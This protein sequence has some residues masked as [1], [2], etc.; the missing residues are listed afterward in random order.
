MQRIVC[1]VYACASD[2]WLGAYVGVRGKYAKRSFTAFWVSSEP[3]LSLK[4]K[5]NGSTSVWLDS[6]NAI[7]A[8]A[9][10]TGRPVLWPQQNW[11]H[12]LCNTTWQAD[13]WSHC[14][15]KRFSKGK[16]FRR[17]ILKDHSQALKGQSAHGQDLWR[18][19]CS[20]ETWHSRG[21]VAFTLWLSAAKS[22]G[23]D[24]CDS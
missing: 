1:F 7:A 22:A 8:G 5:T 18:C 3:G 9:L 17:F 19:C 16:P 21:S 6:G 23:A 14:W 15:L 12:L 2:P 10:S 13:S 24:R 20:A 11:W 4:S